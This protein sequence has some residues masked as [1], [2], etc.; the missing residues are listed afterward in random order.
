M[1]WHLE[2]STSYI[3]SV[4]EWHLWE[5]ILFTQTL[6]TTHQLMACGK[7]NTSHDGIGSEH[8]KDKMYLIWSCLILVPL[9][10]YHEYLA[11]LFFSY[12]KVLTIIYVFAQIFFFASHF[13]SNCAVLFYCHWWCC[14]L[15]LLFWFVLCDLEQEQYTLN[16]HDCYIFILNCIILS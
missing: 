10:L 1:F 5:K 11:G 2:A 13:I 4:F 7:F 14:V 15:F 16:Y 9:L 12:F 6:A 8:V 3:Y